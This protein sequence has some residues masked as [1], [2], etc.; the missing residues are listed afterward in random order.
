MARKIKSDDM[1]KRRALSSINFGVVQIPDETHLL[2]LQFRRYAGCPFCNLHLHSLKSRYLE[3]EAAGIREVVVFHSTRDR[4]LEK[5]PSMPFPI[6][7][8]PDKS[9]YAEFGVERG[10]RGVLNP[11]VLIQTLRAGLLKQ[12][13]VV[14]AIGDSPI[15]LPGDFLIA[16]DGRVLACKYGDH[17]YDQ[18]SVD[19]LLALASKANI[20][21][22]RRTR[23]SS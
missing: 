3:L 11:R 12:R 19:E 5:Q 2:H 14:P 15:G 6:I 1:I 17:A 8:D 22:L 20:I 10:W 13:I 4:L 9:L 23:L 21:P 16:P 18:W 7:A